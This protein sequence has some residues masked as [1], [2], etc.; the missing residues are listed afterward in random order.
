MSDG[1]RLNILISY[2]FFQ[3]LLSKACWKI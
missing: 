3:K 2:M 1:E